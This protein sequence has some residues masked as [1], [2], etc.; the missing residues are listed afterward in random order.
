MPGIVVA[1]DEWSPKTGSTVVASEIKYFPDLPSEYS[2]GT[3]PQMAPH[4]LY[5]PMVCV[6]SMFS[7]VVELAV[8][9]YWVKILLATVHCNYFN[10]FG[11]DTNYTF[12]SVIHDNFSHF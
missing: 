2:V 3:N 8:E 1:K 6:S 10:L 5:L 12:F 7:R 4:Y 9:G 11:K